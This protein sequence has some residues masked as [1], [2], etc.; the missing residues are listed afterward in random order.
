MANLREFKWPLPKKLSL[1]LNWNLISCE[2][3]PIKRID[4][5]SDG[6]VGLSNV[7]NYYLGQYCKL[8]PIDDG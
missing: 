3:D 6:Q 4:S 2:R 8:I 1:K 5:S 7:F